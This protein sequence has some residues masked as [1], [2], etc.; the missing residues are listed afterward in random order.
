MKDIAAYALD[1][2]MQAGA[3]KAACRAARGRKEEFNVEAN[4]FTLLRTLFDDSL[5]LKVI[6]DHKKAIIVVNK[7]DKNSINK[8]VADCIA[9]TASAQADEAEDIAGKIENKNFDQR[10]GGSDM[11][12]L[13]ARTKEFLEQARDEFPRIVLEGMTSEFNSGQAAYVNSNGVEFTADTENYFF[14]TMFSAKDGEKTSSFNGSGANL[15]SL[16][17]PFMDIS[18]QRTL[19]EE[20][21][22]SLDT[23]MV[24][25]KF[26]GKVIVT[27]A[28]DD[29]IW[30]TLLDCFLSD[31]SMIEG[32]SRWKDSLG[33]KVA[34]SKL[35][36][37]ASPLH[38]SVV[39]GERFTSDGFE[40]RDT[41]F[42]RDGVLTS[43]GLS[44]YGANKTGRPRAGNTAFG[45]IEVAAGDTPLEEMIKNIDRGI[46]LNRF[47][48]ASPGPGGD[49]SGVAKNSFLIENGA[50]TGA[51]K[52]T[53][54]SFN[55]VDAL[56]NIPAISRER[57][58]NGVTV[59]PW[60]CFEGI[61]ISGK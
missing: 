7:L 25:E 51:L 13:F 46:L 49:V 3:D 50:V 5:Y 23:R 20:S 18:M 52:E 8:A 6:K 2:L 54:V 26:T 32:T 55:I 21:V 53:M 47:S 29:M 28:C 45:N 4:K 27:P 16:A 35:T 36:F 34:D 30:Q 58:E 19:L 40:S 14:S 12:T 42:I 41:D 39:A 31:S 57:C 37:R 1:A 61:T 22:R 60:C 44:L 48:G 59:L 15:S 10:I 9:L 24:D 33:A 11:D 38:P 17:K 43:F 56:M